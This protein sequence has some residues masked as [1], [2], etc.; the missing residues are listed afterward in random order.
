MASLL[1]LAVDQS[2][3]SGRSFALVADDHGYGFREWDG[4]AAAW[5]PSRSDLLSARHDL[6]DGMRIE[7]V[8]DEPVPIGADASG[9]T[10]DAVLSRDAKAWRVAF[11]GLIVTTTSAAAPSSDDR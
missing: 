8:P 4:A 6:P 3:V 7:G 10:I 1:R 11:D 5:A 9:S 2:L